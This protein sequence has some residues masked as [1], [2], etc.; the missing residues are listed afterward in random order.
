[1]K[2]GSRPC[3]IRAALL[4][5]GLATLGAVQSAHADIMY[6]IST[7]IFGFTTHEQFTEPAILTSITTVTN[8]LSTSSTEGSA[9][10]SVVLDPV[11]SG[12]CVING[13]SAAGP[14]LYVT[15]ADNNSLN[16]GGFQEYASVGT[17]TDGTPGDT[18]TI[19]EVAASVP[20]PV[21]IALLATILGSCAVASRKHLRS[22]RRREPVVS[23]L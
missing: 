8:F 22:R 15:F 23:G 10:T 21:S 19:S 9:V 4:L 5:A 11:A 3:Y 1:M 20:E 18:V 6:D 17:F 16:L 7:N 14:C 12:D 13:T 2:T